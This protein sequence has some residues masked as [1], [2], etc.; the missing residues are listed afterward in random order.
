MTLL[1]GDESGKKLPF[2]AFELAERVIEGV[3][4][5]ENWELWLRGGK[6]TARKFENC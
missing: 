4:D 3:L 5:Y 1:F 2:D 6:P